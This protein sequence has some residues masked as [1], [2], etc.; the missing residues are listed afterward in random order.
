MPSDP[1]DLKPEVRR[2]IEE[3]VALG[4]GRFDEWDA[5][6]AQNALLMFDRAAAEVRRLREGLKRVKDAGRGHAVSDFVRHHQDCPAPVECICGLWELRA[7]V[8]GLA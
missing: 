3:L 7:A 6:C 2:C 4:R 1:L 8:E 5:E